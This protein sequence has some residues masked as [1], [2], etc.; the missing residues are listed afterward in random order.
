M[1]SPIRGERPVFLQLQGEDYD[2]ATHHPDWNI[3]P[4][5]G[6]YTMEMKHCNGYAVAICDA[7][8]VGSEITYAL[9]QALPPG[10]YRF[11]L[12]IIKMR[13]GGKNGVEI[14][15]G[16]DTWKVI[17]DGSTYKIRDYAVDPHDLTL[18]KPVKQFRIKTL[19]VERWSIGDVPEHPI[20]SIMLDRI[21]ITND[22]QQQVITPGRRQ[23]VGLPDELKAASK[24]TKAETTFEIRKGQRI[25]NGSFE[26]GTSAAWF[27]N[28]SYRHGRGVLRPSNRVRT[29]PA[30]GEWCLEVPASG[31]GV[32]SEMFR[33][34][35]GE[36]V[37]V[38]LELR[39]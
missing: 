29:K 19:M 22:L 23:D 11:F 2:N 12:H 10:K 7:Q 27:G 37:H 21:T 17:W 6:W 28:C 4:G 3:L 16:K 32:F 39:S 1:I 31:F 5:Q 26:V 8:S 33:G 9:K 15:F 13:S 35:T 14:S 36:T 18:T 25:R 20:P 34:R 38:S 30:H 24:T